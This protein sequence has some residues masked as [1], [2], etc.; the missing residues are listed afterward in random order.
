MTD[1]V[2]VLNLVTNPEARFFVQQVDALE[3]LGIECVNMAPRGKNWQTDQHSNSRSAIDYMLFYPRVL[4]ESFGPYDLIHANYGLTA[5]AATLQPN[6]PVVLSLWGSDLHGKYGPLSQQCAKRVDAVIVMSEEMADEL[7]V[8]S[9]VIP[10]GVDLDRFSP[11]SMREARDTVGWEQDAI[12]VL[13]PYPKQRAVKDYPRAERVVDAIRAEFDEPIELQTLYDIP[14]EEMP[15]YMNA[16]DVLLMT[17]KHEGSPNA[18]KEAMA[19]NL[20]VVATDVGD[21]RERLDGVDPS[22]VCRTDEELIDGLSAVLERRERSNGRE[23]IRPLSVA[24][25]GRQIA[26]VYASVLGREVAP[27]NSAPPT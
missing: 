21:V 17:S 27:M 15:N 16:A 12:Q 8:E 22:F 25:M 19:C 11:G 24:N 7:D 6:L 9:Y 4:K 10:H 20:P 13:F 26:D 18:V 14:H 2:R 23:V 1:P 3:S 5:P